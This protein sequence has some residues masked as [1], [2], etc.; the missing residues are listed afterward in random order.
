MQY[1]SFLFL[2][3]FFKKKPKMDE[4]VYIIYHSHFVLYFILHIQ[5]M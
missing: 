3:F 2:S 4:I 1:I 5:Y